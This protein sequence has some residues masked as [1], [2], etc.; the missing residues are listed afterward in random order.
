MTNRQQ[1]NWAYRLSKAYRKGRRDGQGVGRRAAAVG[2]F[3]AGC[4]HLTTPEQAR[5][6]GISV[7]VLRKIKR[8]LREVHL[9]LDRCIREGTVP[10]TAV[11]YLPSPED[12]DDEDSE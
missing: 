7:V 5:A 12:D 1:T 11:F 3:L 6:I 2:L 10:D 4:P 9:I 8:Q